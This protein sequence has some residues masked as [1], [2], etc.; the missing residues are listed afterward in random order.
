MNTQVN[1]DQLPVMQSDE[2]IQ[3]NVEDGTDTIIIYLDRASRKCS[4]EI[5][6]YDNDKQDW[7]TDKNL[8]HDECRE[9]VRE[10]K[11]V[12]VD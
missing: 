2:T 7:V 11:L 5:V 10:H 6:V 4:G 8:T 3:W 12:F 9:I 1:S